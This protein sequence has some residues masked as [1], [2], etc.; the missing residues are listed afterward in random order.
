MALDTD[1]QQLKAKLLII[2]VK[3]DDLVNMN[4]DLKLAFIHLQRCTDLVNEQM[5]SRQSKVL[6][7][8]IVELRAVIEDILLS[9]RLTENELHDLDAPGWED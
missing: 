2:A 1:S 9:M 6:H 7:A 3:E 4:D 5:L 8:N